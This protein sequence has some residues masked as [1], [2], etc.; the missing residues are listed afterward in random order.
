VIATTAHSDLSM[1]ELLVVTRQTR[2]A[3]AEHRDSIPGSWATLADV[4]RSQVPVGSMRLR[5]RHA[6]GSDVQLRTDMAFAA[7]DG[8]APTT[9]NLSGLH[10]AAH[11]L[12]VYASR[13]RSP[14]Y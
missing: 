11:R 12:P 9:F 3:P 1:P 5:L 4:P 2:S 6:T 7:Q 8:S 14:V 10:H 13:P